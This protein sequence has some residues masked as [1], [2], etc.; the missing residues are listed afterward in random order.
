MN[1]NL[2]ELQNKYKDILLAPVDELEFTI[3]V[4]NCFTS[5]GIK[6]VKDLVQLTEVELFRMP[7]FGRKSLQEV[8]EVLAGYNLSLNT[9]L[10]DEDPP[11]GMSSQVLPSVNQSVRHSL[12]YTLRVAADQAHSNCV[13]NEPEKAQLFINIIVDILE[14]L[15][16]RKNA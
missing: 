9:K 6:Q 1:A 14:L 13:N 16:E 3:R 8:K 10:L 4:A 15:T 2:K 11:L 12:N 7:G 5:E